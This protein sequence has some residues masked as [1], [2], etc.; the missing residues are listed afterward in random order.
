[1]KP[2]MISLVFVIHKYTIKFT[3]ER[4]DVNLIFTSLYF[5]SFPFQAILHTTLQLS[6][7]YFFFF[8]KIGT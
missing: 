5:R 8:L 4:A 2:G 6:L 7:K 1:M 3:F